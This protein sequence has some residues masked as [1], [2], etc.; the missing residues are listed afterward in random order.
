M[1]KLR[2]LL[3][4]MMSGGV[5][6]FKYQAKSGRSQRL[7]PL[8]LGVLIGSMMLL[9]ASAMMTELNQDG[10][11]TVILSLYTI[12]T[13]VIIAME[14]AYK[15]S[16]LLFKPRDNDML[17]AMPIRRSTIVF[18]RMVKFYLFE[19]SAAGDNCVCGERGGGGVVCAGGDDDASA[20]AGDTDCG[21]VPGG[22]GD[23]GA[24][25]EISAQDFLA[26][27]VFV[28]GDVCYGGAGDGTK[29]GVS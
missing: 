24:I 19:F 17:L 6:L 13:A 11:G 23:C 1:G 2:S 7:M 27:S 9:S 25:G 3:K 12:I 20:G 18:A 10:K 16:D 8:V 5:Q 22:A 28:C 14:G 4:A 15:A 26:G 21:G 29:Y